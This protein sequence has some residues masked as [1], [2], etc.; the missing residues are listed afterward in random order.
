MPD[1]LDQF[2][3]EPEPSQEDLLEMMDILHQMALDD[4][5]AEFAKN[6]KPGDK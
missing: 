5:A 6:L 2:H 4:Y 1:P 3:N